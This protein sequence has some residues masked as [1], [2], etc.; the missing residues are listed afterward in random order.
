MPLMWTSLALHA[1]FALRP[2]CFGVTTILVCDR[3]D[4]ALNP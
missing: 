4:H 1:A 2:S 3:A